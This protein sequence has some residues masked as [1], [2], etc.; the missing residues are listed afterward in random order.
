M[1]AMAPFRAGSIASTTLASL[2]LGLGLVACATEYVVKGGSSSSATD[3]TDGGGVIV[4]S[5]AGKADAAAPKT[6]KQTCE[7]LIACVA[8]VAPSQAGPLVTLYGDASNCWKGG[9][10]D[11]EACGKACA[12]ELEEREECSAESLDG[13]YL[14]L[15]SGAGGRL[16]RYSVQLTY[17]PRTGGSA[18]YRPLP[19]SATTFRSS[20]A[21]MTQPTVTLKIESNGG[22][23]KSATPFDVPAAAIDIGIGLSTVRVQSFEVSALKAAGSSTKTPGTV[24]SDLELELGAPIQTNLSGRC[25]YLPNVAEGSPI[26]TMTESEVSSCGR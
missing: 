21:L 19:A 5:D 14:A 13:S 25:M 26:P 9:A 6:P 23:G 1:D 7:A 11:A 17:H 8:D 22:A 4:D 12:K 20:D 24:C 2:A 18:I 16:L 3:P 10:A 15:C